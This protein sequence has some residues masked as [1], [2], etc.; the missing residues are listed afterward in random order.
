MAELWAARL[1][2]CGES[3]LD[4][5]PAC[6]DGVPTQFEYH[7]FM[8]ID[9]KE[10]ARIRKQAAQRVARKLSLCGQRFYADFGILRASTEDYARPN[11]EDDRVVASFDEYNSSLL[12]EDEIACHI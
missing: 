2:F 10:Q 11:E 9:H 12:I 7:P 8:F 6:V 3:Q 1:G 4:K 5:L